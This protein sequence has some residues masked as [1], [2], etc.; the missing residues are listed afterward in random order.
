MIQATAADEN[1]KGNNPFKRTTVHPNQNPT[2]ALS[3]PRIKKLSLGDRFG[4]WPL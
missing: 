1:G 3:P 4:M 2:S